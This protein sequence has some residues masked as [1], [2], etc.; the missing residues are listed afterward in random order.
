MSDPKALE[1]HRAQQEQAQRILKWRQGQAQREQ[2]EQQAQQRAQHQQVQGQ[3]MP[4]EVQRPA[5]ALL[6]PSTPTRPAG[7]LQGQTPQV[8][9]QEQPSE[10]EGQSENKNKRQKK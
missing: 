4:Q 8:P 3:P 1:R 5:G 7:P 9:A 6:E 10:E 2:Q